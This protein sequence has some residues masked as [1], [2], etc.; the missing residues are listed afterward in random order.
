MSLVVFL[1]IVASVVLARRNYLLGKS[2]PQA[3][4]RLGV[5][6]F[7]LHM[8]L[9]AS[10]AH[11]VSS[12]GL[13]ALI[14]LAIS[15]SLFLSAMLCVIYSAIEPFVRRHWP[16]AIISWTRLMAGKI[17]DPH[18]GRD[19]LYGVLLGITWAINYEV[20]FYFVERHGGQPAFCDEAFF[21]GTRWI[22]GGALWHL[23]SSIQA[24]LVLFM[25]MFA[26]RAL[27]RKPWLAAIAFIAFWVGTRVAT[28]S[29][30][31]FYANLVLQLLIY[32]I[33]A[34]VVLR[35]GF[36]SLAMGM[37]SADLMLNIPITTHPSAWYASST[38]FVL[39]T[40]TALA[41]WGAYTSLG[42]QKL[43]KVNAFD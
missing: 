25:I 23:A 33:A 6:V 16:Q 13:V 12:I 28:Q 36:I 41:A 21:Q 3:A 26:F 18:V 32:S 19:L 4:L 9:W 38:I 8:A 2:D 39:L 7:V 20:L 34:F 40:V 24:M 22:L 14:V 42:G 10:A 5:L 37:F 11:F 35:F 29:A 17:R 27:L 30:T 31:F 15:S 43:W 1:L